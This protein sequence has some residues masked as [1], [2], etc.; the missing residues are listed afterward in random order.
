MSATDRARA[1]LDVLRTGA[2]T[3]G[4]AAP[5]DL[6]QVWRGVREVLV[7]L[8]PQ[9]PDGDAT[10]LVGALRQRGLCTLDE[11]HSLID[12]HALAVRAREEHIPASGDL[13]QQIVERVLVILDRV[14][15]TAGADHDASLL[16]AEYG[17]AAPSAFPSAF[18]S[19]SPSTPPPLPATPMPARSTASSPASAAAPPFSADS[20]GALPESTTGARSSALV[21]AFV[22]LCLVA[23]GITAALFAG[24]G[25]SD[26]LADGIAA[27]QAGQRV[28]ARV[29]FERA[30]A[31][32]SSDA[33]PLVYLGRLAREEGD[34]RDARRLL[35]QAVQRAPDNPLTHRELAS[36]LLADG[37]PELARRFYVRALTLDASDRLAQ[38]FLGCA[39]ARLGRTDEAQR[40]LDRAGPGDWTVC[41][42]SALPSTPS[43]P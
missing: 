23:A 20:A 31:K 38:G 25:R 30:F 9:A 33:R 1:A 4:S 32:D 10:A 11:A 14:V 27:Y 6:E 36:A 29:A 8:V 16:Q 40:W 42:S 35:E 28:A 43:P 12:L 7:A 5:P 3:R 18:P 37:E 17:R 24:V 2:I 22:V 13:P 26:P 21:V 39:L 15:T 19:T 41:A 34:L